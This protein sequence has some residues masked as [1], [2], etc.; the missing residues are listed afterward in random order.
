MFRVRPCVSILFT[1]LCVR[2]LIDLLLAS[3]IHTRTFIPYVAA[4]GN[5]PIMKQ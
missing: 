2:V 1:V 5:R 3:S 4:V